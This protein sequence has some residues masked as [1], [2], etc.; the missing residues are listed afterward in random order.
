ME[1]GLFGIDYS[2]GSQRFL[3][4]AVMIALSFKSAGIKTK[5]E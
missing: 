1:I 5:T 4:K 3:A 2:A